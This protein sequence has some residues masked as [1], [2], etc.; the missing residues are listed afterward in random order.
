MLEATTIGIF[1]PSTELQVHK[2][3]SIREGKYVSL[4]LIMSDLTEFGPLFPPK[5]A[6]CHRFFYVSSYLG[7]FGVPTQLTYIIDM[8]VPA[9]LLS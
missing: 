4:E 5:Y 1:A 6:N 7:E 2:V 8:F 3:G 9:Y